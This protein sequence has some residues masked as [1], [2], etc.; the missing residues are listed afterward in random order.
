MLWEERIALMRTTPSVGTERRPDSISQ[1]YRQLNEDNN[2]ALCLSGGGIRSAA[3]AL[4]II[5]RFAD[6]SI[7]PKRDTDAKGSVLQRLEYLSTV[8]GGGY[9]GS[10][11]SV[12]LFQ[13]RQK[14]ATAGTEPG[15]ANSI[16]AALT[17]RAESHAEFGPIST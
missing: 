14:R 13:E 6:Q 12:W 4:G 5:Q 8:S 2:W 16:V 10:W 3:F 1:I 9:I 17:G 15:G 11:L 7:A